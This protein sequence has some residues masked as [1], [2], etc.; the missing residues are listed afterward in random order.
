MVGTAVNWSVNTVA[1]GPGQ[2]WTRLGIPPAGGKLKLAPDGTPDSASN[3]EAVH[4]GYTEAGSEFQTALS[5][6]DFFVDEEQ[7]PIIKQPDTAQA[8]ITGNWAQ[9]LDFDVLE[10]ML[11][12][13]MRAD[14]AGF[15]RITFGGN[16]EFQYYSTAL[17]FPLQEN[18]DLFGVF[19]LY[20]SINDPGLAGQIGRK[21]MAFAPFAFRGVAIPSRAIGDRTGAYWKQISIGS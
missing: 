10:V 21:K 3:P 9:I 14:G 4:V 16:P 15:E 12:G 6:V 2:V 1:K 18:P 7:D 5:F 13:S 8:A 11:P 17:I 19:H 20:K